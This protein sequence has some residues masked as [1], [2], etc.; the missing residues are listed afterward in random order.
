LIHRFL[1]RTT[2]FMRC[3]L[4][5]V[6]C[7]AIIL[8]IFAQQQPAPPS[9]IDKAV[10]LLR[11]TPAVAPAPVAQPGVGL[12]I[13]GP[14]PTVG[15]ASTPTNQLSGD[16]EDKARELLR[17]I[18]VGSEPSA[19]P[20]PAPAPAPSPAQV[21]AQQQRL[22]TPVPT[23]PGPVVASNVLAGIAQSSGS[24][25]TNELTSDSEDKARAVLRKY[26]KTTETAP[27]TA[28]A[29]AAPAPTETSA[30][31]PAP[32]VATTPAPAPA[33]PAVTAPQP[34][35]AKTR[36]RNRE[37]IR[38]KALSD[39]RKI[40]EQQ[41]ANQRQSPGLAAEQDRKAAADLER[42][43]ELQRIEMEVEKARQAREQKAKLQV[44]QPSAAPAP[45]P[46]APQPTPSPI[47]PAPSLTQP[48]P[49]VAQT[50]IPESPKPAPVAA[51]VQTPVPQAPITQAPVAQA[52][53]VQ[54]QVAQNPVAQPVAQQPVAQTPAPQ[55]AP[56]PAPAPQVA[57]PL[58]TR[59]IAPGTSTRFPGLAPDME[60]RARD[61][62]SQ[63]LATTENAK[64]PSLASKP[65]APAPQ[66]PAPQ[67][68]AVPAVTPAPAPAAPVTPAQNFVLPPTQTA[69]SLPPD[70]E[71]EARQ[72]LQQ[73][74]ANLPSQPAAETA[75]PKAEIGKP[76]QPKAEVPKPAPAPVIA[77]TPATTAPAQVEFP[78]DKEA[79]ARQL[80]QQTLSSL[81]DRPAPQAAKSEKPLQA[82]KPIQEQPRIEAPKVAATP[83]AAPKPAEV[84]PTQ[85]ALPADKETQARQILEQTLTSLP[86]QS[87]PED[88]KA[89]RE[90]EKQM[91]EQAK[92]DVLTKAEA[93]AKARKEVQRIE[94]ESREQARAE[95][96]RRI[97]A[98]K[99]GAQGSASAS[100]AVQQDT[101]P[102]VATAKPSPEPRVKIQPAVA[103]APAEKTRKKNGNAKT[104]YADN[105]AASKEQR[106]ADLLQAYQRDE[107]NAEQY[108][109]QRRR[110]I[111]EP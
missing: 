45:T 107:I 63:V 7:C 50:P 54:P 56:A 96:M 93:E 72:L 83:A 73:T 17:K 36:A 2:A 23:R 48:A 97:E 64:M 33:A 71:T 103:T 32:A 101:A 94:Q 15:S 70:K 35:D 81:L 68:A 49:T 80:L 109:T 13:T 27:Q 95:A 57:Q 62:L 47:Q 85:V 99:R 60:Q 69:T 102:A 41:R 106:L 66:T 14:A 9:Q 52:P 44:A 18:V 91:R 51:P 42:Q 84:A 38:Q 78:A 28:Q 58:Q 100:P 1:S 67:P 6:A 30:A 90:A 4:V 88:P 46:V 26:T 16:S 89:K 105:P 53:A 111:S 79:Q 87:A 40:A 5:L 86:V 76:A 10:E 104:P 82:E 92:R 22:L 24:T 61:I 11:Q 43:R 12:K 34:E 110:I 21:R 37:A 74:L 98:E 108:H 29:P 25:S 8:S 77:A 55:A 59:P 65:D 31:T 75:K 3:S 20:A 19:A 39:A